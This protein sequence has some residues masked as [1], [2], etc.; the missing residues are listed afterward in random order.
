MIAAVVGAKQRLD[1]VF[2]LVKKL[3]DEPEIQSH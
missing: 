1:H 3:P 2:E